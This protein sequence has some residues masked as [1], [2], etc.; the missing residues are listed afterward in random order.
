MVATVPGRPG[1]L[2]WTVDGILLV[3]SMERRAITAAAQDGQMM[4]YADLTSLVNDLANDLLVNA[5]GRAYVGNYGFDYE[6]G[7]DPSA[8][9]L[10]R[11]NP[12]RSVH[13]EEP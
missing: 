4:L 11:V 12:D 1:G 2:D 9:R 13:L 5:H 8:T 7:E 10:V 6:H 3:V